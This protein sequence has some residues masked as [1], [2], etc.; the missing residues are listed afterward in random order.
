MKHLRAYIVEPINGRYTNKKKVGEKD[1]LIN[2]QIEDH[3]FVNRHGV[4]KE[5][6]VNDVDYLKVDDEVIVHHNVFRRFYDIRGKE[7][8]GMSFFMEDKYLCFID[9]IFL[10]KRN[11]KWHTPPGFCF[12]KP[13]VSDDDFSTEKEKPLMGV[14]KYNN[15]TLKSIENIQ[16]GNVV[17]FT[18]NSEYEF[19]IDNERLYRVPIKS[20]AINYGRKTTEIEYNPSWL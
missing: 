5:I 14:L 2:T 19:I 9:Q 17:G 10:Y 11:G 8:N 6:P 18:P 12:V 16:D 4:I 1:L 7:K 13:V 3:K 15:D 20:I